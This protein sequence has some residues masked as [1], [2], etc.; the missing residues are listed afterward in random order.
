MGF[1]SFLDDDRYFGEPGLA[2]GV[3]VRFEADRL[4]AARERRTGRPVERRLAGDEGLVVAEVATDVI[5]W[6][7]S[8]W[9]VEDLDRPLRVRPANRWVRCQAFTV[10][11]QVPTWMVAGPSG[12]AV[13]WVISRA[14]ALTGDQVA[15]LAAMPGDDEEPLKQALWDRWLADHR[16]G[17]P[18]G[19]GLT[20]LQDAVE[21]A[22]RRAGPRLFSWDEQDEVEVLS[23]PAW[24]AA[25]HAASG[26]A[27]ALGAPE[28]LAPEERAVL[29]RRWT[30][31]FGT[32][33]PRP[34]KHRYRV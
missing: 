17:S 8:L 31:L 5:L 26:A 28:L 20:T 34:R 9:R 18:V 15:A 25:S 19:C 6:P 16:S 29:A 27:L 3:R 32:P 7:F 30:H 13:E 12:Y 10:V 2:R 21:A 22:A 1:F 4:F 23:D 14:R 33:T 11:E 24:Q